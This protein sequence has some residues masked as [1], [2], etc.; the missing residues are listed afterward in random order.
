MRTACNCILF[1]SWS[2]LHVLFCSAANVRHKSPSTLNYTG[3]HN[4]EKFIW[5]AGNNVICNGFYCLTIF[6]ALAE[7]HL[8]KYCRNP[9]AIIPKAGREAATVIFL[10]VWLLH[11]EQPVTC[12][13][14]SLMDNCTAGPRL[15]GLIA[16][17]YRHRQAENLHKIATWIPI[18]THLTFW[19]HS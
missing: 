2:I 16:C 6:T 12:L 5:N 8:K 14:R 13:L 17:I 15:L 11:P 3:P 9:T 18:H 19:V 1:Q 10:L 4:G 7:I